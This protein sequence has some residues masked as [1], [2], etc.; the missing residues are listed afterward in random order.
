MAVGTSGRFNHTVGVRQAGT[1]VGINQDP[2]CEL[3]D[4]CDV[5]LV[6]DW[7]TALPALVER[8]APSSG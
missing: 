2:D 7:R 6:A 8:L 5:G 1:I 4:C 3:W